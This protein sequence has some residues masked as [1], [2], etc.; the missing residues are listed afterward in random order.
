MALNVPSAELRGG[1]RVR[2]PSGAQ[3]GGGRCS[4]RWARRRVGTYGALVHLHL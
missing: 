2:V 3:G 1:R 4:D